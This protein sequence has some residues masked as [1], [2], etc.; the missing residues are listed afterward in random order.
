MN[1]GFLGL[2]IR[3]KLYTFRPRDLTLMNLKIAG[4]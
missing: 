4:A 2:T 1:W 3:W